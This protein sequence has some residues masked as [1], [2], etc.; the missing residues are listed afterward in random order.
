MTRERLIERAECYIRAGLPIPLD[1]FAQLLS[2]G[3][4]VEALS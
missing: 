3:V 2:E 4:D 1:L